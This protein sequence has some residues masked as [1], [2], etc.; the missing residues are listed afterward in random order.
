MGGFDLQIETLHYFVEFI[1]YDLRQIVQIFTSV[2][3]RLCKYSLYLHLGVFQ[4]FH[5]GYKKVRV[6][7]LMLFQM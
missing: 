6:S 3:F 5:F 2:A 7:R 4:S 1:L